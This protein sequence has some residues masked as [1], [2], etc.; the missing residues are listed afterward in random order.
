VKSLKALKIRQKI[1]CASFVSL[2]LASQGVQVMA[3]VDDELF[4]SSNEI[5]FYDPDSRS[6]VRTIG[7]INGTNKQ[8]TLSVLMGAGMNLEQASGVV[9]NLIVES[10]DVNLNP[11][12]QEI[13]PPNTE[14]GGFGIVQWTGDRWKGADGLREFAAFQKKDW[15]DLRVQ[16]EF[17]LWEVGKGQ[18]WNGKPGGS[19]KRGWEATL[20]ETTPEE[21]AETWMRV[22][23]RPGVP[24]LD[25]RRQHARETYN[26]FKG[27]P[28][29]AQA[30]A[31]RSCSSE[32]AVNGNI[33]ET[34]RNLAWN[35]YVDLPA[36][37]A[38]G[39]GRDAAKPIYVEVTS[40][41]TSD[42][43]EAYFTDCGAF[44]A[45]VMISSG[46]DPNYPKRGTSIQK[47]YLEN[48]PKYTKF[49]AG[50]T[51]P[52]PGDILIIA[53]HTYI[54]TDEFISPKGGKKYPA[55]GASLYS[56]PPSAHGSLLHDDRGTYTIARFKGSQ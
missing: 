35:Y 34:A 28:P 17:I 42:F 32:G 43:R 38:Y 24:H 39:Y 2:L 13:K 51:Q 9:G 6:C 15:F 4:R 21:A 12:A 27:S 41:I 54:Y 48:S 50:D 8:M 26:E 45:T 49:S 47:P 3:A 18:P 22:Y 37:S 16:L 29:A 25:L 19:E 11:K 40:K 56:R 1:L 36:S 14:F 7:G 55:V 31:D 23:E 44:V 52:I 30:S 53:G 33:V 5:L 20:K 46:V 10:G